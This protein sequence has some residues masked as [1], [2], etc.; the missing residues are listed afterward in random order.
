ML[1]SLQ[2]AQIREEASLCHLQDRVQD[3]GRNDCKYGDTQVVEST[4]ERE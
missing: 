1:E 2:E 4:G 3:R